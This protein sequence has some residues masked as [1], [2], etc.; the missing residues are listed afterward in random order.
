MLNGQL[1]AP[2][3][4]SQEKELSINRI[5]GWVDSR[6]VLDTVKK[7]K[8]SYSC[9][10]SNPDRPAHSP[11][12]HRLRYPCSF[13]K[14]RNTVKMYFKYY[15]SGDVSVDSTAQCWSQYKGGVNNGTSSAYTWSLVQVTA[16]PLPA[17]GLPGR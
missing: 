17:Y 15:I 10:E 3:A 14:Y 8:M 1:H 11:S 7:I 12:F 5:G 13:L 6:A 9:R 4:L 16:G 2:A